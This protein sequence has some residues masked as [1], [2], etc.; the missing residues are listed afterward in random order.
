VW[1]SGEEIVI[2][3][4]REFTTVKQ[5]LITEEVDTVTTQVPLT[6]FSYV[7]GTPIV[8]STINNSWTLAHEKTHKTR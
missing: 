8:Q 1:V 6:T 4:Y 7:E 2:K 5:Q 3:L